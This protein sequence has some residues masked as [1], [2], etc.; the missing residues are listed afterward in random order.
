MGFII[1]VIFYTLLMVAFLGVLAQYF[2]V[3]FWVLI[4]AAVAL[5]LIKKIFLK[6]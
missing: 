3:C 6:S 2:N 4:I 1:A 5:V